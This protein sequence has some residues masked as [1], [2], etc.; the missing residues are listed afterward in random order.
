[1]IWGFTYY[2]VIMNTDILKQDY[3]KLFALE[4]SYVVDEA[5]LKQKMRDL[6]QQYHPDN[7]ANSPDEQT[8]SL[9]ISSYINGA[10][11]TLL[12]PLARASYLLK[13]RGVE[14]DLVHDTK[15]AA[16]FLMLQ[17][18]LR[19]EIAAAEAAAD[20]DTLTRIEDNLKHEIAKL[21]TQIAHSF[22]LADYSGIIELI[23]K[24]AFFVKLA[25]LVDNILAAL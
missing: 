15:F 11:Q 20:F 1:M 25:Q 19:E 24:L 3:F 10:Y 13:L 8:Q 9:A 22:N 14:V 2:K 7:F 16:D 12:E 5:T 21:V 17:I 23:K 4:Q 6:Q 18:E